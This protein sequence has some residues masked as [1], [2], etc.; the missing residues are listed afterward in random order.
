MFDEPSWVGACHLTEPSL[1]NTVYWVEPATPISGSGS[2]SKFAT[3]GA[4]PASAPAPGSS[5]CQS[6]V[7]SL[8]WRRTYP[9]ETTTISGSGSASKLATAG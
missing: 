7:P 8:S 3:V 9:R 6:S 2:A 5:D 4:P 1:S